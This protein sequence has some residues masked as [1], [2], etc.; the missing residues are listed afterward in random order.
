MNMNMNTSSDAIVLS[1]YWQ[2]HAGSPCGVEPT[3]RGARWSLYEARERNEWN[4][5]HGRAW[6]HVLDLQTHREKHKHTHTH[7]DTQRNTHTQPYS[8]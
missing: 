2:F 8:I 1:H 7:T 4:H 5:M 6:R 3:G